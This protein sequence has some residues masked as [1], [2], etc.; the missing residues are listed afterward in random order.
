MRIRC[1]KEVQIL[2]DGARL[3]TKQPLEDMLQVFHQC[4]MWTRFP[5]QILLGGVA[6]VVV[7]YVIIGPLDHG[8]LLW[9]LSVSLRPGRFSPICAST[10]TFF[11]C[12][13]FSPYFISS[14]K[15][16]APM[17]I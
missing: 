4:S 2:I 11:L 16:L 17:I 13:G 7:D 14:A 8:A 5:H 12:S 15:P 3:V 1:L 10:P 9:S 6:V